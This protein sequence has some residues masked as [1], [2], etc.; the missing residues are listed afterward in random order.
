[1]IFRIRRNRMERLFAI[2]AFCAITVSTY[3]KILA[4]ESVKSD[5]EDDISMYTN[6]ILEGL[7]CNI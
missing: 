6:K 4:A 7:K 5:R 2:F 3:R 1:M